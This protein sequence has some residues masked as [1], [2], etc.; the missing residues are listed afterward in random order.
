MKRN[1]KI[2]LL[3][4]S[5]FLLLLVASNNVLASRTYEVD[6]SSSSC[7]NDA[8]GI[9]ITLPTSLDVDAGETFQL[10]VQATGS[11][12]RT[13]FVLKIPSDVSQNDQFVIEYPSADGLVDDNDAADLDTDDKEIHV[14]YNLT[15]PDFAGAF[16]LTIYAVQ[17][18]PYGA[19]QSVTINVAQVGEGPAIGI[20]STEPEVPRANQDFTV[21]VAITSE[22]GVDYVILQYSTTNGTSW[23]NVTMTE[24]T[25]AGVYTGTIPGMLRDQEVLWRIVAADTSGSESV[26]PTL[27][28]VVGQIPVEPF[29]LPQ[30]HY[31]WYIG[32]PAIVL[33]YIGTAL[34]YYDEERF[35]KIHGYML[36]IAYILT[37]L[38]VLS[39][40]TDAATTL[41]Y[42]NP[43]YLV[44]LSNMLYFMHSWHIWLGII[45]IILGTLAF[46]THL[47]GWKT[48]NLGL[49]AVVLWTILGIMGI[50]LG[51]T[52][53]M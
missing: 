38:N 50:Y 13:S 23:V 29:V 3:L 39:L 7:H 18:P 11:A 17:N 26:G 46:I 41:K 45:S 49:P 28:Y 36:G 35:T 22:V 19:S 24:T 47:G 42:M 15:A 31:G 43:V 1:T 12:A 34:E 30:F 27:T 37:S 2:G 40:F 21:S 44:D 5:A 4:V 10:D 51:Q 14:I 32:A 52:F 53:V 8:S 20:P 25:Q 9:S 48:C 6:C 33:A 16:T